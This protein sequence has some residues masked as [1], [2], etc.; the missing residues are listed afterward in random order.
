MVDIKNN[1]ND[2]YGLG[3]APTGSWSSPIEAKTEGV[4]EK[5]KETVHDIAAEASE[6]YDKA[7]ETTQEWAAAAKHATQQWASSAGDA[8]GEAG[9]QVQA[10]LLT[11]MEK[12]EGVCDEA[13]KLIRRYPVQSL[14]LGFGVGFLMA[15]ATRRSS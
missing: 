8:A 9:Q 13:T 11:A 7:K 10:A 5:V 2:Q 6:F 4:T 15:Q 1:A 12:A 14:L 3:R